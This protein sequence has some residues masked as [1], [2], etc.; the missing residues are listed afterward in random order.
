MESI[1]KIIK[2]QTRYCVT[3]MRIAAVTRGCIGPLEAFGVFLRTEGIAIPRFSMRR[4]HI[5]LFSLSRRHPR[6][7]VE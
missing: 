3:I 1:R 6:S 2:K 5:P 7:I 4:R